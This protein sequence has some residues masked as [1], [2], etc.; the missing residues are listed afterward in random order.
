MLPF[1]QGQLQISAP[2]LQSS[3]LQRERRET[4]AMRRNDWGC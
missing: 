3:L 1:D 4:K 2:F